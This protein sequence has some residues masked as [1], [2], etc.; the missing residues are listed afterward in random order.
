MN[1][2]LVLIGDLEDSQSVQNRDR[3][4]LQEV[5]L[6]KLK[7]LNTEYGEHIVSPYTITLGDEFQA[8]FDRAD[9]VFVQMLKIMSAIHPIG[10]RFSL[11]VG[12]IDT[13]INTEQAIGMDGPAFHRARRGIEQLKES[14]YLFNIGFEDEDSPE[15]R[16]I[17]NSLQLLSGEMRGWNKRRLIILHMMKDGYDYKEISETLEISKPAFYKN[18]DAGMLDVVGEL[19]D[20]IEEVI[21][22]KLR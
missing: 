5:L 17:N 1:K 4:A 18:K 16:I 2:Q 3:E 7:A 21:N 19:G 14:G 15:L 6:N 11:A 9:A 20:N 10:V 8:V 22:Q 12:D 13:P